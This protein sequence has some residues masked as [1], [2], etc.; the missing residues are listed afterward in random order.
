METNDTND[1]SST[2]RDGGVPV[3]AKPKK[4]LAKVTAISAPTQSAPHDYEPSH[5]DEC[6]DCRVEQAEHRSFRH[7]WKEG[8][9]LGQQEGIRIVVKSVYDIAFQAGRDAEIAEQLEM[10][11]PPEMYE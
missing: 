3:E 5:V 2:G 7:G 9:E 8:R 4:R 1:M 11:E 6:V 10:I